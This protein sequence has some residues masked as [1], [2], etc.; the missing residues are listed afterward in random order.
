MTAL[1]IKNFLVGSSYR[2]TEIQLIQHIV[3]SALNQTDK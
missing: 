1:T 3:K 2:N